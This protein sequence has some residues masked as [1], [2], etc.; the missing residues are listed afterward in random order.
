MGQKKGF[1]KVKIDDLELPKAD[2]V[3]EKVIIFLQAKSYTWNLKIKTQ[4]VMQSLRL[5]F[6]V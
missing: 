5:Y 2:D 4:H 3:D 1:D 6:L